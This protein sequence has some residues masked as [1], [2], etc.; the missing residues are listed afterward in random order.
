VTEDCNEPI[1]TW[2]MR[3]PL[4]TVR[5]TSLLTIGLHPRTP[6]PFAASSRFRY[7][8]GGSSVSFSATSTSS[9]SGDPSADEDLLRWERMYAEGKRSAEI[10]GMGI[11]EENTTKDSKE[12]VRSKVH[13]VTYD[14]DNTL[15]NTAATI[16]AANDAL[17]AHIHH[18]LFQRGRDVVVDPAKNLTRVEQRMGVLHQAQPDRYGPTMPISGTTESSGPV[19]LTD[20]RKDAI[21]S[22]L[23]EEVGYTGDDS[24]DTALEM[25]VDEAFAVWTEARHACI[26]AHFAPSGVLACL[27]ALRQSPNIVAIGAI[28]DGNSNPMAIPELR[29]YFDF[30][31]NAEQV[32]IAKPDRRVY[33]RAIQ[34]VLERHPWLCDKIALWTD[35]VGY[36]N[37]GDVDAVGPWWVHVGDDFVKDVVAA[38]DLG[39]RT[40]WSRELIVDKLQLDQKKSGPSDRTRDVETFVQEISKMET[41]QMEIG[42]DD[43][44]LESLQ[45][46]F[47]DEIVDRFLEVALTIDKWQT[48]AADQN[49]NKSVDAEENG[50]AEGETVVISLPDRAI[51]VLAHKE[52]DRA[53]H[54]EKTSEEVNEFKFCIF[55]GTKLPAMA[56]FCSS[57]GG[58]QV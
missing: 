35:G 31:I 20:L 28:T 50:K 54:S 46:E 39:M 1:T 58:K 52:K 34:H 11:D 45:K 56:K 10:L 27:Q 5:L 29:D 6:A 24:D 13:V 48:E 49:V 51:D 21:R 33:Q 38:K 44:L 22:V 23:V 32:G 2:A 4:T 8:H 43:Y 14:L 9:S 40:I 15:W 16:S 26:P 7:L 18:L 37:V 19:R 47:A 57:C 30:C 25:A 41:I 3:I 36:N 55:C 12:M 53:L 17:A 42:A